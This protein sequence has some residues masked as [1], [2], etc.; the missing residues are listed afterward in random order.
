[1][2]PPSSTAGVSLYV[3]EI[4]AKGDMRDVAA[5]VVDYDCGWAARATSLTPSFRIKPK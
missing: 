4:A 5:F 3:V 1:M 2:K